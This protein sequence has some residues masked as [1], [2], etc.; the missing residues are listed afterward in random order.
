[1]KWTKEKPTKIG[2]YWFLSMRETK[3]PQEPEIVEIIS[4]F[5]KL[6]VREIA[7]DDGWLLEK[8]EEGYWLGPIKMPEKPNN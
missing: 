1:M 8:Y 6:R 7:V 2:Y 4:L 3:Y 5:D